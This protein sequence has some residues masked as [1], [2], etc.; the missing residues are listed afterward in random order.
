MHLKKLHVNKIA[1]TF[2]SWGSD[3]TV[4]CTVPIYLNLVAHGMSKYEYISPEPPTFWIFGFQVL[5]RHLEE[6]SGLKNKLCILY[7][8]NLRTFRKCGNLRSCDPIL[9]FP[10]PI[11]I[12]KYSDQQT[13]GR[14]VGSFA[15]LRFG[16]F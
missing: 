16:G 14:L 10:S 1:E 5:N 15:D 6:D 3:V 11:F 7:L 4:H 2:V 13:C 12:Y 8:L 9:R